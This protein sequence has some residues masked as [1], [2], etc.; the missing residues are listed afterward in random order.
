MIKYCVE[1]WD[2]NRDL[3]KAHLEQDTK[4][5][6]CGWKYLVELVVKYI[7]NDGEAVD[8]GTYYSGGQWNVDSIVEIDDGDYQGTL[9][10]V[11]PMYTYQPNEGEYLMASVWYGSCSGCD[12]LQAVQ[13]WPLDK[14]PSSEQVEDFMK[15]CKDIVTSI[16]RPYNHGWRYEER[17]DH[18]EGSDD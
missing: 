1:K 4:L 8:R 6:A 18:V 14:K 13:D 5:N 2:K 9:L 11:I 15:L 16:I 12:A 10:Y 17:F 3:L 7:L